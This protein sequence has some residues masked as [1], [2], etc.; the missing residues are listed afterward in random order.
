MSI[1]LLATRGL[2]LKGA[3]ATAAI[4]VL[5][6]WLANPEA[7]AGITVPILLPGLAASLIGLPL[8]RRD[9]VSLAY[10]SGCMGTL[11]GAD[12]TNLG[13]LAGV[14]TPIA[15]IGGAGTFDAIFMIALIA[16][17]A[18]AAASANAQRR[19]ASPAESPRAG[20]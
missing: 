6:H 14:G 13:R 9:M 18:A 8:W 12:L 3:A 4:A 1:Y 11:I 19:A 7:R 15:S 17:S 2:W 20:P 5:V 10:I 16:V